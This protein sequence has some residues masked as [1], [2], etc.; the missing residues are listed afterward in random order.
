MSSVHE[1][2]AAW[3][4]RL[5]GRA[6]V[7][8]QRA[9]FDEW[10]GRS[11]AHTAAYEDALRTWRDLAAM[12]GSE[13]YRAL[14]GK[15]TLRERL[16]GALRAPRWVAVAG[17]AA[18]LV[19]VVWLGLSLDA[20]PFLQRPTQVATQLAEVRELTLPDGTRIVLGAQ[21]QID[22]V[23]TGKTRRATV[24]AGDAFFAVAH[25]PTRPFVVAAG[26]YT[27]RVVGTQFEI[28]RRPDTVRVAVSEGLVAV[29]RA[30][31]DDA[32]SILSVGGAW[33]V[34]TGGVEIRPVDA[35]D[36]GAWRSGRLV[37]DNA[38]LRDVVADA[39]RY[40][41]THIVVVDP[42]LEG[43][44]LTTSFR[45]SQVD[46]M[47]ETLQAALPLVAERQANGDIVLRARP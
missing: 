32:A 31:T 45:T 7:A 22:F 27:V 20:L 47:V 4:A 19:A 15:P 42:Q 2:A 11:P 23:V 17:G 6:P 39:N 38:A 24:I 14:L 40:T 21:S 33:T 18:A 8:D 1:E 12:R 3:V 34:G 35:A 16:V 28:R 41:R 13:Q 30:D 36:V 44:R 37:Y 46:G 10:I 43:L 5:D 25:D 9:A 29:K 26:D